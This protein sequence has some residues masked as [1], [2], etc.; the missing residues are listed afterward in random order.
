MYQVF[1][2]GKEGTTGLQIF[3]KLQA[4]NDIE[5]LQ[6]DSQ[7]RKIE[8]E[9]REIIREADL[10]ILC[11]PD[12]SSR[13]VVQANADMPA[14]FIDASTA[15]RTDPNW[16]YGLPELSR[17]QT[18]TI[19]NSKYVSNPGCYPTGFLMLVKP[20]IEQGILE[21]NNILS[22][23]AISGY[24]GG[25]R[26]LIERYDQPDSAKV[27]ARLYGLNMAHKHLP[28][29]TKYSGLRSE[30]LFLPIVGNFYRGMT[31]SVPLRKEMFIG[32]VS[33]KNIHEVL[34]TAYEP[35]SNIK[36]LELNDDAQLEKGFLNP[37]VVK[38]TDRLEIFVYGHDD[39]MVLISRL[40][41]LGKG[42]SGAAA[43]NLNLMLGFPEYR[44]LAL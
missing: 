13:A 34:S 21:K 37:Q 36:V 19:K 27:S 8:A 26:K 40:D 15:Y 20:L 17:L 10:V 3:E 9:K 22:I 12:E 43:Q 30:P 42:A 28:E 32:E 25:G 6:I 44:G 39:Q 24:S 2:D 16:T 11:L 4:R 1:I 35:Y 33:I 31:V 5:I 41:N 14:K 7:K 18:D 38:G 29:M 23:S